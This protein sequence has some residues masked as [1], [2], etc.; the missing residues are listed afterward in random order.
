MIPS[1]S[2][3]S[4]GLDLLMGKT[5]VFDSIASKIS[6]NSRFGTNQIKSTEVRVRKMG[7]SGVGAFCV[8]TSNLGWA[9]CPLF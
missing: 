2:R 1:K 5:K 4:S 8:L 6:T 9:F 3:N 7:L